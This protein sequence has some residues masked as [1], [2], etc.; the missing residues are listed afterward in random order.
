MFADIPSDYT[1]FFYNS[2]QVR[3]IPTLVT[4]GAVTGGL[5]LVDQPGWKF[6]NSLVKKYQFIG[7]LTD[8][9]VKMGDGKYQFLSAAL[10]AVPGLVFR[11]ETAIRTGSN[12]V[13]A[14]ISSGL[15]VQL[16]KRATGRQSPSA[17]TENGGDWD[18]FP[19]I[20][21]YQK[22]QPAFY[23]F[24]SG[25]LTTTTAIFTVIANNYPDEKWIKPVSYP[26]LGLLGF[27][28]VGKGMHWYSDLPF[29]YFL[30]Y[31]FGNII[32]TERNTQNQ[33]NE[34]TSLR[35]VPSANLYGAQ[36]GLVYNF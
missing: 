34:K 29:A 11:D 10:F 28:L 21:Q 30:G 15:F 19:S 26:L 36:I 22:N 1:N 7:K 2:F 8:L 3:E 17:S 27:S 31:S 20:K 25:H 12:I 35:V 16:L 14:V 18:P 23:S 4:F 9:S 13:E 5:I 32:A 33:E 24:P 6:N